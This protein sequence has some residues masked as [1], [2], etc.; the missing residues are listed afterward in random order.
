MLG[1]TGQAELDTQNGTVKS[2]KADRTGR[3]GLAE[4]DCQDTKTGL[5]GKDGQDRAAREELPVQYCSERVAW[6]GLPE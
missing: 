1:R 4:Q 6:T 5:P 3:T 2:G